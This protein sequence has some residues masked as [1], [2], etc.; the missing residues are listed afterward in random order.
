MKRLLIVLLISFPLLTFCQLSPITGGRILNATTAFGAPVAV[1]TTVHNTSTNQYFFCIANTLSTQTLTSA[2]A[3]F[4]EINT[5]WS[6]NGTSIYY[7]TG[8]IG[9]ETT[10][11]ETNLHVD[12]AFYIKGANGDVNGSG[13]ITNSDVIFARNYLLAT[14]RVTPGYISRMDLAGIGFVPYGYW[15]NIFKISSASFPISG[16]DLISYHAKRLFGYS[17]GHYID[18]SI[19]SSVSLRDSVF[20]PK[21]DKITTITSNDSL[22]ILRS[23]VDVH[24]GFNDK[25]RKVVVAPISSLPFEGTIGLG[26]TAQYWRGDKSW[27]TLPVAP[28]SLWSMKSGSTSDMYSTPTGNIGI[29]TSSPDYKLHVFNS[30]DNA[31][32]GSSTGAVGVKGTSTN[33][34]GVY[35]TSAQGTGVHGMTNDGT[36]TYGGSTNG[37]GMWGVSAHSYGGYFTSGDGTALF[38]QTT[39]GYSGIFMGGNVGIGMTNPSYK[40]DVTSSGVNTIKG[41]STH[42]TGSGV[43][44]SGY[45][46]VFGSGSSYGLSGLSTSGSGVIGQSTSS[47]GGSFS[48]STGP[49]LTATSASGY[50]AIFLDG[51]IGIGTASPTSKLHVVGTMNVTGKT[52]LGDTS[53][54]TNEFITGNKYF[55]TDA[56]TGLFI[57]TYGYGPVFNSVRY[58]GTYSSPT[59]VVL[60]DILLN[61]SARGYNGSAVTTA[62]AAIRVAAEESWTTTANGTRMYF[63]TTLNGSTVAEERMRITNDG[64]VGIGLSN[65]TARFEVNGDIHSMKQLRIDSLP[66]TVNPIDLLVMTTDDTV[67]RVSLSILA[68]SVLARASVSVGESSQY[69]HSDSLLSP[70]YD[71]SGAVVSK[72]MQYMYLMR[73]NDTYLI[74]SLDGG[75]TFEPDSVSTDGSARR[76][77]CSKK[78]NIVITELSSYVTGISNDYGATFMV[79]PESYTSYKI[80][81]SGSLIIIKTSDGATGFVTEFGEYFRNHIGDT[82]QQIEMNDSASVIY[83]LSSNN[84]RLYKSIDYGLS[85]TPCAENQLSEFYLTSVDSILYAK[86]QSNGTLEVSYDYGATFQYVRYNSDRVMPSNLTNVYFCISEN[87]TLVTYD[88]GISTQTIMGRNFP[89]TLTFFNTASTEFSI[90]KDGNIVLLSSVSNRYGELYD[91]FTYAYR[92]DIAPYHMSLLTTDITNGFIYSGSDGQLFTGK[93]MPKIKIGEPKKV[94]EIIN[95]V[96][97]NIIY[98]PI[99]IP[100]GCTFITH[101]MFGKDMRVTTDLS[102]SLVNDP[103]IEHG[104]YDGQEITI[105][106]LSGG[107][108]TI[109]ERYG[110]RTAPGSS[111]VMGPFY[112]VTLKFINEIEEWLVVSLYPQTK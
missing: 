38:A 42:A 110:W 1:G 86:D 19:H 35:G 93:L 28:T 55:I 92:Y 11:P 83:L 88:D 90:S 65:P 5:Q 66:V 33:S 30:T 15:Y 10:N 112:S 79:Q 96:I 70:M 16:S 75:K 99:Y 39:S 107:A 106:C 64:N 36:G 77:L 44:G 40:L 52:I 97:G 67:R 34:T 103:Q 22:A 18:D 100:A 2:A 101:D 69:F 56:N 78:G 43:S 23:C 111:L 12:G 50:A 94:V 108:F 89:D 32:Y 59:T 57:N 25:T 98:K 62:R 58:N 91:N 4:K 7:N 13:N 48:S 54:I 29:G 46:G 104:E 85:F 95:P 49:G 3:N 61:Q 68:D 9:I 72:G 105:T 73:G 26:T 51:N 27:Q 87:G 84:Y 60:N 53:T 24:S 21:V 81:Y 17:Y 14:A 6:T 82:V 76:L 109:Y 74:R 80:N 31:I 47:N 71:I 45:I 20:L 102:S 37:K 63:L 41:T 8:N